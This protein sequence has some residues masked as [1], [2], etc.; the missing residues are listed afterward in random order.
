ME[1]I[2]LQTINQEKADVADS[3]SMINTER[4]NSAQ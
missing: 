3:K 1:T 2:T 4:Y